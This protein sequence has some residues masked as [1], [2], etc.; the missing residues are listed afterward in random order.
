MRLIAAAVLALSAAGLARAAPEAPKLAFPLACVIGKTCEVQHYVDRDPG[1]GVLDYRC[2]HRTNNGHDGT[3]IRLLD[4]A[5]QRRGVDVLAAAAGRVVAT[6]DGVADISV[7]AAGKAATETVAC[8]NRVAINHGDGWITDYCHMAKGSIRVKQGDVVAA[9][10]PLGK[11][12][13]SG[14]TEFPHLHISVRHGNVV[15]DPFAAEPGQACGVRPGLWTPEAAKAMAYKAGAILTGGF[16][17][18]AITSDQAADGQVAP[19]TGASAVIAVYARPIDLAKGDE[20]ELIL[21]GPDGKVL[22]QNRL[23]PLER[24]Q[25]QGFHMIGRKRPATGWPA[26]TYTADIKVWR[27]GKAAIQKTA[28]VKL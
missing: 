13:L 5:Q 15:V 20:L 26:G 4:M 28:T 24:D 21:K 1:P 12:G 19:V 6:R 11:V 3:D 18:S 14:W 2:G 8:G 25:A 22:A 7:A 9:G 27:A 16:A 23:A 17:G 10:Q